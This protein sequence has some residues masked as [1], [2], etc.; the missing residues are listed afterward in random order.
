MIQILLNDIVDS[1]NDDMKE[2]LKQLQTNKEKTEDLEILINSQGGEVFFGFAL[3]N[4]IKSWKGK[5]TTIISG[6]AC[7]I[8]AIIYL[9]G[10]EK[11]IYKNSLLMFH[12]ASTMAFGTADDMEK[13]KEIL[14]QIDKVTIDH[15]KESTGKT[16]EEIEQLLSDEW[17]LMGSLIKE[18]GLTDVIIDDKQKIKE[19][20]NKSKSYVFNMNYKEYKKN[21]EVKKKMTEEEKKELQ[22]AMAKIAEL[23]VKIATMETPEENPKAEETEQ[24]E[25]KT[26]IKEILEMIRLEGHE[27]SKELQEAITTGKTKEQFAYDMLKSGK[28]IKKPEISGLNNSRLKINNSKPV[29][30]AEDK[31][32][33][34]VV[35]FAKQKFLKK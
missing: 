10:K 30:T 14:D 27:I 18:N 8:A 12:K 3:Y 11:R 34:A 9:A 29:E 13:Q 28:S 22:N 16:V 24:P 6:M 20:L 33:S 15:L 23:E 31:N 5:T 1:Y 21:M 2:A 32:V 7:S 26:E 17:Y 35:E 4:A 25:E 19:S